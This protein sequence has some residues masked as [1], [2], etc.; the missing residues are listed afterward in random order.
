MVY[1]KN[2]KVI[3]SG[4]FI[5]SGAGAAY[6]IIIKDIELDK[7]GY[8]VV[9]DEVTNEE[10]NEHLAIIE[11]PVKP[12][13]VTEWSAESYYDGISSDHEM[14]DPEE[15][16]K[17][18]GGKATL[19]VW[20]TEH[21]EG[22]YIDN[23]EFENVNEAVEFYIPS[24]I[25]IKVKF[26]AGWFHADLP[27]ENV[28]LEDDSGEIDLYN[29]GYGYSTI[30]V[31]LICPNICQDIN[32]FFKNPEEYYTEFYNVNSSSKQIKSSY[33]SVDILD[34][35]E[36]DLDKF[37]DKKHIYC[38]IIDSWTDRKG[39]E[40]TFEYYCEIPDNKKVDSGALY[41]YLFSY[42]EVLLHNFD[43][44][45]TVIPRRKF[46]FDMGVNKK[47][48]NI[49]ITVPNDF[50]NSSHKSIK[51]GVQNGWEVKSS[52]ATKALD[53]WVN[54]VGEENALEDL[55]K[56]TGDD[57]LEEDIEWISRQW[58]IAEEVEDLDSTW[59][60]YERLKELMGTHNLYEELWRSM[61]YDELADCMAWIFNQNDFQ[62]WNEIEGI[63]S[64]KKVIKSSEDSINGLSPRQYRNAVDKASEMITNGERDVQKICKVTKLDEDDINAMIA[65][66]EEFK[67]SLTSSKK[68]IKSGW[69][70]RDAVN[71]FKSEY[72]RFN[73]YWEMQQAWEMFKDSLARDGEIT[74]K[75]F[76][77][78]GNPCTPESFN[79]WN[80]KPEE[81]EE[82]IYSSRKIIKSAVGPGDTVYISL[83]DDAYEKY[84]ATDENGN[85]TGD[86]EEGDRVMEILDENFQNVWKEEVS[87][88]EDGPSPNDL[89]PSGIYETT[90]RELRDFFNK[91]L[92]DKSIIKV[93]LDD[94]MKDIVDID[95]IINFKD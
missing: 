33:D 81:V 89:I 91:G 8:K 69:T 49:I 15:D 27:V 92:L 6:D 38:Y 28:H 7:S 43:F 59:D 34:K 56:A 80:G 58:G 60:K 78:W 70:F 48:I 21:E 12:C 5:K 88:P 23:N 86:W 71:T 1:D 20:W 68:S 90:P 83:T 9:S 2:G 79:R 94:E 45:V 11:V 73:D 36:E 50:V 87:S 66:Q 85:P 3:K 16:S 82:D 17:I 35:L 39:S 4:R 13:V 75:Q 72:G 29:D 52:D 84:S 22:R 46:S 44:S 74:Q 51:S 37:F 54:Y 65:D 67:E 93:S 47:N 30:S 40:R 61:G 32:A 64:S 41:D 55:A 76:D 95:S 42:S 10:Y 63:E 25:S 26:G 19:K 14:F 18:E 57:N 31:D 77:S 62:E 24:D 53:M